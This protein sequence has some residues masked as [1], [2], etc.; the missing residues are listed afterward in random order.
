MSLS[1]RTRLLS[2]S[3]VLAIGLSAAACATNP[4]T[5]KRQISFMNEDQEIRIGQEM[6][7]EV[8]RE[9]GIYQDETLQKYVEDIGLQ[10]GARVAAAEPAVALHHRGLAGRSTRSRCPAD[11]STSRAASC[12]I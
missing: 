1:P 11:T 5:G 7:A 6:D 4:V 12:R 10:A 2:H 8:R 9:M 3:L